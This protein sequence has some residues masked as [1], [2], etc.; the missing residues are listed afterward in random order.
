MFAIGHAVAIN[1][2]EFAFSYSTNEIQGYTGHYADYDHTTDMYY[3]V[4]H[5]TQVLLQFD[6]H[7]SVLNSLSV[8]TYSFFGVMVFALGG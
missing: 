4:D 7:G 1:S 2:C 3:L 8:P 5:E 6:K